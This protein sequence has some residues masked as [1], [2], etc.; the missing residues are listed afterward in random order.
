MTDAHEEK[1]ARLLR[2]ASEAVGFEITA[3]N[4]QDISP[5]QAS[6]LLKNFSNDPDFR[7]LALQ[8]G[9]PISESNI[10]LN[11]RAT[12]GDIPIEDVTRMSN[13][14]T[15]LGNVES[16]EQAQLR[17]ASERLTAAQNA[18]A[19]PAGETARLRLAELSANPEWAAKAVIRGTAEARENIALNATASGSLLNDTQIGRL[20]AGLSAES[21]GPS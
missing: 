16:V 12:G 3:E 15:P 19:M 17:L 8:R 9:N 6:E 13:G 11:A 4:Y 10:W 21:M 7:A 2:A 14:L 5:A 1:V 20:A 18:T